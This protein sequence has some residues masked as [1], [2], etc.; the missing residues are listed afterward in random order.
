MD[1]MEHNIKFQNGQPLS[2]PSTQ[3]TLIIERTIN[4][5]KKVIGKIDRE[6][7]IIYQ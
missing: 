4:T 3:G 1:V 2:V 7:F 5:E 6:T